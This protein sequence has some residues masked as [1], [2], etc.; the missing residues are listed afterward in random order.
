MTIVAILFQ[1]LSDKEKR[2]EYDNFG[3]TSAQADGGRRGHNPFGGFD[4]S[5]FGHFFRQDGGGF[6][7]FNFRFGGGRQESSVSKYRLSLK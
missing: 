7:G 4:D 3:T 5:P 1:T 6:G 2:A